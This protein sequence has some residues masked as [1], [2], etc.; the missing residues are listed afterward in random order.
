MDGADRTA[1]AN[2]APIRTF[3]FYNEC[4]SLSSGGLV[5]L[6]GR[7]GSTTAEEPE[8]NQ[9]HVP[10]GHDQ[11][12]TDPLRAVVRQGVTR[13]HCDQEG[14]DRPQ[15]SSYPGPDGPVA[16]VDD[17]RNGG[18]GGGG[19][20]TPRRTRRV[21]Q[22]AARRRSGGCDGRS[23]GLLLHG[24][25]LA[26]PLVDIVAVVGTEDPGELPGLLGELFG[27]VVELALND[28]GTTPG[29]LTPGLDTLRLLTHLLGPALG[30]LCQA[31]E[32][33]QE[34]VDVRRTLD[35][36]CGHDDLSFASREASGTS[37]RP[38]AQHGARTSS[39]W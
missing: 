13:E 39:P 26:H 9:G 25:E 17:V 3:Y 16:H 11:S 7:A 38:F 21:D 1:R 14:D 24:R 33:L 6:D 19:G 10:R 18:L 34:L 22:P 30:R 27:V 28:T 4:R 35:V 29:V 5:R 15:E 32:L 12:G 8:S 2:F 37:L 23:R 36:L 31:A 20:L